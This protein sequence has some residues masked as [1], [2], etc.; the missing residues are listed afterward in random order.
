MIW[1]GIKE[2]HQYMQK[3]I[4]LK[5]QTHED[6]KI[7]NKMVIDFQNEYQKLNFKNIE[8]M[9]NKMWH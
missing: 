6:M 1:T 8:V 5:T 9:I 3:V 4:N 7:I 2:I